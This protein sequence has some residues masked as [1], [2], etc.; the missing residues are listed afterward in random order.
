M[1]NVFKFLAPLSFLWFSCAWTNSHDGSMAYS[2]WNNDFEGVESYIRYRGVN[3]RDSHY[4]TPLYYAARYNKTK[5]AQFLIEHKADPN[6]RALNDTPFEISVHYKNL[7]VAKLLMKHGANIMSA[8]GHGETLLHEA[9]RD[10]YDDPADTLLK[11]KPDL[12]DIKDDFGKTPLDI[13][14]KSRSKKVVSLL[15]ARMKLDRLVGHC[16]DSMDLFV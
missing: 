5:M 15:R 6:L 8:R 4:F 7:A 16:A 10:N 13:A 1:N 11:L 12:I 9:A 3:C 2:V 14:I